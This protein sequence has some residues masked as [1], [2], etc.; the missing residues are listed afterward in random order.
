MNEEDGSGYD[1]GSS[2]YAPEYPNDQGIYIYMYAKLIPSLIPRCC[3][4]SV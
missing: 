2:D 1:M 4:T 3:H